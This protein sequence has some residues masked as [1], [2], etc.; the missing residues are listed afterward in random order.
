MSGLP[1][2]YVFYLRRFRRYAS[3]AKRAVRL[4]LLAPFLSLFGTP[5]AEAQLITVE[6]DVSPFFTPGLTIWNAGSN[7]YVGQTST[8]TLTISGGAQVIATTVQVGY[9]TSG[10]INIGASSTSS[11]AA[12]G[13]LTATTV[14]LGSQGE[15]Y[16]KHTDS[17]YIFSPQITGTGK[18]TQAAGTTILTGANTY[19]GGTTISGGVLQISA[20]N[21]L[22][23]GSLTMSGGGTLATTATFG[24]SRNIN[25]IPSGGV[26][27]VASGT[28]L[29][30]S[31]T[32]SNTGMLT[33]AGTGTMILTGTNTYTGG[34]TISGG[35][36]QIGNGGTSGSIAGG[37]IAN[38]GALILN[39]SG[40]LTL[41][42]AISGSG[43]VQQIG[44]GTAIL[45]GTN[46]YT[47]GTT[48]NAGT[49]QIG[50]G[51]A[52][53]S[54]TGNILNN[55]VLAFNTT[56]T[57]TYGGAISGTGSVTYGTAK[58]F[59]TADHTYTGGSTITAGNILVLGSNTTTGSIVGNITNNGTL[60]F[61]R[62]N[63]VTFSNVISGTGA[64]EQYGSN[65]LTLTGVN[66]YTGLT[67][68]NAGGTLALTGSGSIASSSEVVVNGVFDISAAGASI[69][70]LGSTA[71]TGTV[72]L[73]DRSLTITNASG[74]FGGAITGSTSS[75]FSLSGGTQTLTGNQG[76]FSG[77]T[78]IG[79]STLWVNSTL[80]GD[81]SSS[82]ILWSDATLGGSGTI[83]GNVSIFNGTL[84]PGSNGVVGTLTINGNLGL[85]GGTILN[86][87][88]GQAGVVGGSM[89]NL[90]VVKGNLA[91]AGTLNV[92]SVNGTLDPGIYRIFNYDGTLTNNGL[93][94]GSL[95]AS[96]G[97]YYIQTQIS[98]QVN[99]LNTTNLFL[100]NFWNATGDGFNIV[101]GSGTWDA[102]TT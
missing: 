5:T 29:T 85:S 47:G 44:S 28:T 92:T 67:T 19:S 21:Q 60:M 11:A 80:F 13:I 1:Q 20:D 25:L 32:I 30:L 100:Q 87:S 35:V 46:T 7:L 43:S 98:G 90:T 71:T 31:G 45:T 12:A 42:G 34:T 4:G 10:T 91:I 62:S 14:D 16:F 8:G 74:T 66:T 48:I 49:L 26:F 95:P 22:G 78:H 68:I 41:A 59:L 6:G 56:S 75:S 33:K 88:F 51:G 63:A 96:I 17:G 99:L 27:S 58:L 52:L 61:Y 37:Q 15:L 84:S 36:L 38:N 9:G 39:R 81:A 23:T 3:L 77:T 101:G 97:T 70:S 89:N 50:N 64:L 53:G 40:T 79:D 24:M 102:G 86:Y 57:M 82:I 69:K 72:R 94:L 65:T 76:A 55:S 2:R 93:T 83:G 18:L 54:I 73:G